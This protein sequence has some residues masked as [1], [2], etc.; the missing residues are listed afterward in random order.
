MSWLAGSPDGLIGSEGLL[1]VKCP[2][3][4]KKDG[5]RIHKEVPTHYYLQMNL[6]LEAT[7]RKWCDYISWAPESYAIY[8]IHR[9]NDLHEMLM[10]HYLK[11]FAAMQ[12]MAKAPPVMSKDDKEF[13][14]NAVAESMAK[15]VDYELW[16]N[17]DPSVAP[18]SPMF[19]EQEE[20]SLQI[21]ATSNKH[22]PLVEDS[23][24]DE[25][26]PAKKMRK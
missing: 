21:D 6:C 26:Q 4:R 2:F 3:W 16:R 24:D 15:N 12:R 25:A 19:G 10:P 1:E 23:D 8:R 7:N 9:D 11:F 13:V 17:V 18:P 14:Q 5:T 20:D 22:V